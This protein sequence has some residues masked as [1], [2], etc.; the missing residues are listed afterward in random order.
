MAFDDMSLLGKE[1]EVVDEQRLQ[2]PP[3]FRA[4]LQ[5]M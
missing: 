4:F 1:G 2:N 3:T 5:N